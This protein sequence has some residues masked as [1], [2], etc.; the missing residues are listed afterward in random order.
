MAKTE[1]H[2]TTFVTIDVAKNP[3]YEYPYGVTI[4][5][6]GKQGQEVTCRS[7]RDCLILGNG[8]INGLIVGMADTS[9]LDHNVCYA[10]RV[11]HDLES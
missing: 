7:L 6:N 4:T 10:P 9:E 2:G 1:A 5:I 8:M 3:T 11:L